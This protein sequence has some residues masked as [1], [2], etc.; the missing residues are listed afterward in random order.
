[1]K[2]LL[3]LTLWV[4]ALIAAIM[5]GWLMGVVLFFMVSAAILM[6]IAMDAE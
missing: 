3:G 1:M 2:W 4:W 5:N 6:V